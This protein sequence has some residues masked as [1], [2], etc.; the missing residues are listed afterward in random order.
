MRKTQFNRTEQKENEYKVFLV[1]ND[2]AIKKSF[3]DPYN[4]NA[5]EI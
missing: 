5:Y 4:I 2:C 1:C 3:N